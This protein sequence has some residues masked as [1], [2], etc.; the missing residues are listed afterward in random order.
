M[1]KSDHRTRIAIVGSGPAGLMAATRLAI[2]TQAPSLDI[3]L[4][5]KRPGMGR[6]LLIAGSSGLNISHEHSLQDFSAHYEGWNAEFWKTILSDFG[7]KDWIQFIEKKLGLETF[8]GTSQRYFV[9]EMKASNLLKQWTAFLESH[10]V[11]IHPSHELTD[12]ATNANPEAPSS[13]SS[14]K[15]HGNIILTFNHDPS[16]TFQCDRAAFFLGGGSWEKETP[17]WVKL[18]ESKGITMVP[19]EPSNVGF[20]VAWNEKFLKESEGKPL[21]KIELHTRRG[22]KMGE[23]VITAYGIEGTPVYF[24]GTSGPATLDLKPDLSSAQILEKL[25]RTK[26][27]LSPMR[28]V[29][30]HLGLCEASESLLFHHAPAEAKTDLNRMVDTIKRFPV[31]LQSPRPLMESIS[32]KGG[33]ALNEVAQTFEMKKIPGIYCAGEMLDWDAP[34][35]GFLIQACV[36]QGAAVAQSILKTI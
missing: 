4:F 23:L 14:E 1:K 28:R 5:E 31:D 24:C 18:F 21:K 20:E 16:K 12:F 34:T 11:T 29:K 25:N 30:H 10:G 2:S 9:R 8:L 3:H 36:S 35:G 27:N 6:K 33:V 13:G 17:A 26:E 32:S 15:N 22:S 19:F 7:P